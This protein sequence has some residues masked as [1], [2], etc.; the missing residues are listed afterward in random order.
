MWEP[1]PKTENLS[2]MGELQLNPVSYIFQPHN[3]T[4]SKLDPEHVC[5]YKYIQQTECSLQTR[6][7]FFSLLEDQN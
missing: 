1:N 3:V 6:Q 2:R 5:M 7:F 4:S